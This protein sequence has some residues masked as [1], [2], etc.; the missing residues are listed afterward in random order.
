MFLFSTFTCCLI[1]NSES[2]G[3]YVVFKEL[4]QDGASLFDLSILLCDEFYEL[5]KWTLFTSFILFNLGILSIYTLGSIAKKWCALR[6]FVSIDLESNY[7][8]KSCWTY[9]LIGFYS[10]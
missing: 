9:G 3:D 10:F 5:I 8:G 4:S 7:A 2:S 1:P 6:A